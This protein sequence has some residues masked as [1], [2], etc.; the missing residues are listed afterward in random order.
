MTTGS[1]PV[2]SGAAESRLK[3]AAAVVPHANQSRRTPYPLRAIQRIRLGRGLQDKGETRWKLF[4]SKAKGLDPEAEAKH[5]SM[6]MHPSS[7]FSR[8]KSP[9]AESRCREP[10]KY[11]TH[12]VSAPYKNPASAETRKFRAHEVLSSRVPARSSIGGAPVTEQGSTRAPP[13]NVECDGQP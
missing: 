1:K 7:R 3:C 10:E 12:V 6:C 4:A 9:L 8:K 13:C 11:F 2:E 5:I